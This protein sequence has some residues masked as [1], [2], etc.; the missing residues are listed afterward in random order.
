MKRHDAIESFDWYF[1]DISERDSA[2]FETLRRKPK[3]TSM[4]IK[5]VSAN[6]MMNFALW[7]ELPRNHPVSEL[8]AETQTDL[9]ATIYLSYGGFFRQALSALRSWFEISVDGVYFSVHYG[10]PTGRYER[11]KLGQR[12]A[13]VNMKEIA[14][15]LANRRQSGGPF[16][17]KAIESKL[18]PTYSFLSEHTHGQGLEVHKLQD[19]RDNVPRYLPNSF[20]MWYAKVMASF[21]TICFLFRIFFPAEIAS[22]LKKS[23]TEMLRMKALQKALTRQLP[24]FAELVSKVSAICQRDE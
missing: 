8:W 6:S 12:N 16:G 15:S 19:G 5:L 9:M 20:D 14:E 2:R 23:R 24:E 3:E 18:D 22:Y 7:S 13:P 21:D 4:L 10:Q 1:T 17:K 11:W